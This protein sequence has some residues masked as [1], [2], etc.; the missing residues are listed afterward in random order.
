MYHKLR[1]CK[2]ELSDTLGPFSYLILDI[3]NKP[4]NTEM[5]EIYDKKYHK[6]ITLAVLSNLRLF[7]LFV[8]GQGSMRVTKTD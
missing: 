3:T 2:P 4:A 7:Y 8:L 5:I 1:V 6:Y